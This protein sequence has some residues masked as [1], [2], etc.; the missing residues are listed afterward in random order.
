MSLLFRGRQL[1]RGHRL[2]S[3]R[4]PNQQ[5]A[6]L[7]SSK[8]EVRRTQAPKARPKNET[9]Q[10]GKV[11][12][13]HMLEVEWNAENGW[14][15]PR[16][17][18]YGDM[19][20]SPAASALH[21]GLQCFEG[22]KAYKDDA[23]DIR[24][25]RPELNMVRL[26]SSMERMH[27]PSFEGP[28]FLECIKQLLLMDKEWIPNEKG[29]SLYIRPAAISLQNTLG[30]SASMHTKLFCI[31]CP[32]GPYFAAGI[33][34]VHLLADEK[35]VRAWPG[36]TGDIKIGGNYGASIGPQ[37]KAGAKGFSQILWLF[38]DDHQVTEV[39]VM[40]FFVLWEKK[41]GSGKEL[42]TAPLDGTILPGVTR[43]SVID[44]AHSLGEFEITERIFNMAELTEAIND[45]RVI[46]AFGCGTAAVVSPVKAITYKDEVFSVPTG[47]DGAMG[48][49]SRF[50][51]EKLTA[52]QYGDEECPNGWSVVVK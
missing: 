37:T 35:H 29:F 1:L 25:F 15:T 43:R 16:I 2:F 13:D 20:I 18:P 28:E 24:L 41:D 26:N 52:I 22:M 14:H 40:N 30:V 36:G 45:G 49:F 34:P 19:A 46:E 10:F 39:G 51:L 3:S 50:V 27:M 32:V 31:M 9:L 33:K 38:G 12:T 23:G 5:L 21:Y 48:N 11:F 4:T 7:D 8:L 42:I 17:K 6:S 44:L 47:D